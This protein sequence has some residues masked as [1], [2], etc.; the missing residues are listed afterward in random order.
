MKI[1]LIQEHEGFPLYKIPAKVNRMFQCK[2]I[3]ILILY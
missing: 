3:I 1:Y 2:I